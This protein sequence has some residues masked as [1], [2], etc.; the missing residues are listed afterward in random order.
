[1]KRQAHVTW[2]KARVRMAYGEESRAGLTVTDPAP[3]GAPGLAVSNS[4]DG[5]SFNGSVTNTG[6]KDIVGATVCYI[7]RT[8]QAVDPT[9][10]LDMDAIKELEGVR[11]I[12]L[13]SGPDATVEFSANWESSFTENDQVVFVAACTDDPA[14]LE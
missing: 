1:M 14:D 6:A 11:I 5:G 10:G 4:P 13:P 12:Q 2:E 9:E 7:E 8:D 3:E